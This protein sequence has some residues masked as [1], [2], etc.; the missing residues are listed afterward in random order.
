[1]TQRAVDGKATQA[2]LDAVA[3]MLGVSRRAVRLMRGHRSRVKVVEVQDPP[4]DLAD[5]LAGA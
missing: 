4:T 3:D 2:A 1:M 5:R